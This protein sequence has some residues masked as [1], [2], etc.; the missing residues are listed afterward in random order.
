MSILDVSSSD[1]R[2]NKDKDLQRI[3][4]YKA[5]EATQI[6]EENIDSITCDELMYLRN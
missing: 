2:Q 1:C 4:P 5:G 6:R 3:S